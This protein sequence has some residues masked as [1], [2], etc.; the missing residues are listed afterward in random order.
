MP[1]P[2]KRLVGQR[3]GL[4][5]VVSA[6]PSDKQGNTQWYC[7]CDCG[8]EAVV[9]YLHLSTGRVRS[10]GCLKKKSSPPDFWS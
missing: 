5:T 9:R 7:T 4:L 1:N 2:K 8:N 6:F 3:F 10:C